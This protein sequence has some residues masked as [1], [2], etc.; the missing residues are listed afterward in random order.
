MG[1][2]GSRP[3]SLLS[4]P[5]ERRVLA[6]EEAIALA[7][8]LLGMVHDRSVGV[9]I[10]HAARAV[11]TVG[12]GRVLGSNT[13]DDLRISFDSQFGS[14]LPV[15]IQT[16]QLD[17]ATLRRVVAR[18]ASIATPLPLAE[19]VEPDDPDDPKYH[20]YDKREYLPVSLWHDS[21]VA[22]MDSAPGA[23]AAQL[24]EQAKGAGLVASATVG[25]TARSALYMY[26]PGLTA[27][28]QETDCELTVTART[29]DATASGWA[30]AAS[31]DWSAISPST[32]CKAAIDFADRGRHPVAVEPGRRTVILGP[33]AVAQLLRPMAPMFDAL[34]TDNQGTPFS[35]RSRIGRKD[36]LG[37]QVFDPG[38]TLI[39]DPAD[40]DGGFPPFFEADGSGI[41]GL[42]LMK[43]T[44][45]EAG[46]LR[47][48]AYN[49]NYALARGKDWS[50]VP[51]SVRLEPA[52]GT[53]TATLSEMIAN[54]K[55]GIYVNRFSDVSVTDYKTGMMTGVTRD[56]CFHV[57]DGSIDRPLNNY[58]FTESP[59]FV[60]NKVKMI[61]A[62]ERAALGYTP[63]SPSDFLK[64]A[65]WPPAGRSARWP[66]APII[67]P[68]MMID[69]FNFTALAD[70]V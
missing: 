12:D 23:V 14:G 41:P 45:V 13:G 38:L 11:A 37:L 64:F 57:K 66:R 28:V 53:P 43:M 50:E 49:T 70:A 17:D 27:W 65:S 59:F 2:H 6:R 48:L 20:T 54:C 24:L 10:E 5:E 61:G 62:P 33:A 39:S 69:D 19:D 35:T 58:R 21:T 31:R 30:G 1:D 34:L 44:W 15:T 60:F 36:K 63:P 26:Q 18:A 55:E 68:A 25:L 16:N 4:A 67:A 32:V 51:Y 52:L 40:P 56:G 46:I 29:S 9:L 3:L 22:A 42:P 47:N 7:Q 8:K